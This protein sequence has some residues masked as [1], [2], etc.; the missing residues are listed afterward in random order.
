MLDQT[1]VA[2]LLIFYLSRLTRSMG[3]R[4]LSSKVTSYSIEIKFCVSHYKYKSNPS[5][6]FR[7]SIFSVF[8]D[9]TSQTY[10]SHEGKKS[11]HS[12]IYLLKIGFNF[13]EILILIKF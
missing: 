10:A 4:I 7:C 1:G 9:I 6:M 3:A 12:D 5:A 11:S 13:Q 2:F 8:G